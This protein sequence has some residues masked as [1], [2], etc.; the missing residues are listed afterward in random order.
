MT[1]NAETRDDDYEGAKRRVWESVSPSVAHVLEEKS[2]MVE[3]LT[4][5]TAN[6]HA[7]IVRLVERVTELQRFCNG[8]EARARNAERT[9][10]APLE[11][12]TLIEAGQELYTAVTGNFEFEK[13]SPVAQAIH[14]Y[15]EASNAYFDRLSKAT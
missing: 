6:Q 2:R 9:I 5:V 8:F 13:G 15:I 11:Q 14:E 1:T 3:A 12:T 10:K 4:K 7:E